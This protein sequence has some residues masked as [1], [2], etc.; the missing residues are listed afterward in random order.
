MEK[1]WVWEANGR[2]PVRKNSTLTF[3]SNGNLVLRDVDGRTVWQTKTAYKGVTGISMEANGNLVLHDDKGK[4]VWQSFL[5]PGDSLLRGQSVFADL[6]GTKKLVSA[7][8]IYS[9]VVKQNGFSLYRYDTGNYTRYGGWEASGL[10]NLTFDAF[11]P[12]S[13]WGPPDSTTIFLVPGFAKQEPAKTTAKLDFHIAPAPEP[14][15]PS[16]LTP[17]EKFILAKRDYYISNSV[18]KL[19][20]DGDLVLYDLYLLTDNV[21][22]S[23]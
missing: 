2:K 20:S 16:R 5:Q 15:A 18:L 23:Y 9:A 3:G 6:K 22:T 10:T 21:L 7:N 17:S 8:G 4:F 1:L 11:V 14:E 13:P 19:E 12:S